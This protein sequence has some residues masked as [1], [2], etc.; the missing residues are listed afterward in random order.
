MPFDF[1]HKESLII[2]CAIQK[3]LLLHLWKNRLRSSGQ[4]EEDRLYGN[5]IMLSFSSNVCLVLIGRWVV[6]QCLPMHK[7]WIVE[8]NQTFRKK[9]AHNSQALHSRN[10]LSFWFSREIIEPHAKISSIT[11][12]I[13][14]HT[15]TNSF[16]RVKVSLYLINKKSKNLGTLTKVYKV[17]IRSL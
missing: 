5:L 6:D 14:I 11:W 9:G 2:L 17:V 1:I 4:K 8:Y 13:S 15:Q 3:V 16:L 10:N 7:G 12:W